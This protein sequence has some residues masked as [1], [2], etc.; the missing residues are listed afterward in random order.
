[1]TTS[2]L[3][4]TI[5]GLKKQCQR[6]VGEY[7]DVYYRGHWGTAK[8]V[9]EHKGWGVYWFDKGQLKSNDVIHGFTSK[10][11]ALYYGLSRVVT[12]NIY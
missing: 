7:G 12:G 1:M 5:N 6:E 11:E 8:L 10:R 9:R 2:Y 4:S 3:I